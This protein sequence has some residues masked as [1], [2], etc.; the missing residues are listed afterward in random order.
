[1]NRRPTQADVARMAGVSQ[2]TVSLVLNGPS[3]ARARVG[4]QSRR[5]VLDAI[6]ETGYVANPLAQGLARGRNRIV[7]VFTYESVFPSDGSNFYHPFLVGMEAEAVDV[8]VDLLLFTSAP[9]AAGKRRLTDSGWNRLDIADGCILIG[10]VG[11]DRELHELRERRYPVVYIG[12]RDP[13]DVDG[14]VPYVGADYAA[15]TAEITRR[16]LQL[17]HRRI[18]FLGDL[19]AVPSARDRVLGY[20]RAMDEARHRPILLDGGAFTPAEA[21]QVIRDHGATAALL[22]PNVDV[23]AVRAAAITAG[24]QVPAD[25]SL[26]LLGEPENEPYPEGFAGFRIPRVEMGARALRLL[27]SVIEGDDALDPAQLLACRVEVG[28]TLTSAPSAPTSPTV[29]VKEPS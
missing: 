25:L 24:V 29:P 9:V 26:A 1:M 4:E 18:V 7:G 15:A 21:V 17:G 6:R 16:M 8:G 20:R 14:H 2:A 3:N 28:H 22:G 10:R 23:V 27:A 5:R 11:N 12:R 19:S 13:S